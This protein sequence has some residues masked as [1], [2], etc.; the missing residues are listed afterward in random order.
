MDKKENI[1]KIILDTDTY[2]G[3]DDQLVIIF[4]QGLALNLKI[5]TY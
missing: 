2:N 1:K 5:S 3:Y 4:C